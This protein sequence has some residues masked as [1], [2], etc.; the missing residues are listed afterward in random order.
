LG[1]S[2][3]LAIARLALSTAHAGVARYRILSSPQVS[4]V[5]QLA[6][7]SLHGNGDFG[8]T[9]I[10]G[11]NASVGVQATIP[12]FTGGMRSALRHEARAQ[13][14]QA[15]SGL[16]GAELQA[17]QQVR[18]SWLAQV[19]AAARV[20]ALQRLR[21]SSAGRLDATRLGAEIGARTTLELL[22]AEADSLR[23]D[24]DY[25]RAQGEWLLAGLQLQAAAGML[26]EAG[27]ADID[28]RLAPTVP[29]E[30]ATN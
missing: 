1:G 25:R 4:L 16:D 21:A 26:T 6:N 30:P 11:R 7:D 28:R 24:A 2:P 10:S 27:L 14:R 8:Y 15:Q 12:L 20:R 19:N 17:R 29:A 13:E 22:N 9:D 3:Q 18:S 5:A 23:A